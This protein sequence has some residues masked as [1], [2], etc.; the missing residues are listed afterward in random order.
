[1]IDLGIA[2]SDVLGCGDIRGQ[3]RVG[4][5]KESLFD[6]GAEDEQVA[7]QLGEV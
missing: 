3:D 5:L 4:D 2:L 6:L 7:A 1:M